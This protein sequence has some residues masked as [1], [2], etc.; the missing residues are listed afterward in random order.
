[1]TELYYKNPKNIVPSVYQLKLKT[2]PVFGPDK[3]RLKN[4]NESRAKRWIKEGKA[5]QTK[6]PNGKY[7]I[8]LVNNPIGNIRIP[9]V[10]PDGTPGMPT[11]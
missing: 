6:L 5:K 1:M 3:K 10:N 11:K 7:G 2:V 8:I 9:V 4:T